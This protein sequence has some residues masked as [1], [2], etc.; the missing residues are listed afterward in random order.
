[1]RTIFSAQWS[2]PWTTR[3]LWCCT[4]PNGL[5][6]PDSCCRPVSLPV[7]LKQSRSIQKSTASW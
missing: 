7:R 2:V 1:M 3:C 5:F 6:L 4:L